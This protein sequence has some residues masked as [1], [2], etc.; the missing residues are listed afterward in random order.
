V[1][2]RVLDAG[3]GTQ[4]YRRVL[5]E[6]GASYYAIDKWVD[7]PAPDAKLDIQALDSIDDR[8]FDTVFCS[9]VLEYV[10][11]PRRALA[12]CFRVLKPGGTL[13][14][15]APFLLGVHDAP[16]DLFRFSPFGLRA[17]AEGVGFAVIDARGCGGLF[18]FLGHY[19]SVPLVMMSWRVPGL[20]QA[21]WLANKL[22]VKLTVAIDDA[23]GTP[24]LFPVSTVLVARRPA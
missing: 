23:L 16:R 4:P 12:E 19:V 6:L 1:N 15:S 9:Q 24:R 3:C 8:S 5:E 17:L 22:M 20:K 11:E 2:G 18:S 7:D 21:I 13:V 10:D 14:M